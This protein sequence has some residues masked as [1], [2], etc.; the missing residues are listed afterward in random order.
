MRTA[1]D[2]GL[3]RSQLQKIKSIIN[4]GAPGAERVALFGSRADGTRKSHSDIDLV[5]YGN[6]DEAAV[7]RLYTLFL[8]SS[9]PYKVDVTA[10]QTISYRPLK[11]R[12]E[13]CNKTL[14]TKDELKNQK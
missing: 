7:R 9:L 2:H 5:I 14:F 1:L 11:E 3:S 8:E 6:V 13:D 12:I 10:W 4:Q